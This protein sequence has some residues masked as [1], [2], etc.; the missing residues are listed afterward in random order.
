MGTDS[1]N[2]PAREPE[3]PSAAAE[4]TASLWCAAV[5]LAV[6]LLADWFIGAIFSA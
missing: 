2:Q 3:R 1:R 5:L 6:V 4:L